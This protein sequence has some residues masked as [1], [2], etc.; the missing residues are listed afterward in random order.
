MTLSSFSLFYSF[1]SVFYSN[2]TI[3]PYFIYLPVNKIQRMSILKYI[4]FICKK[5][6]CIRLVD[7]PDVST[8]TV[9]KVHNR[10]G[11]SA[12]ITAGS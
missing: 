6:F 3:A 12:V 10:N 9:P 2:S 8:P 1:S 5:G 4:R 7:I 11:T